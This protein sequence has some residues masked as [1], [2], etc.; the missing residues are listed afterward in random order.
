TTGA[1]PRTDHRRA[2]GTMK[3]TDM[4]TQRRTRAIALTMGLALTLAACGGTTQDSPE[5]EPDTGAGQE[6]TGGEGDTDTGGSAGD[7]DYAEGLAITMLPKSV[8]N[9]YFESSSVG[10]EAVVTEL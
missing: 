7:G 6:D 10:A 9:P 1:R 8:N 3:G 2:R 5:E 4:R